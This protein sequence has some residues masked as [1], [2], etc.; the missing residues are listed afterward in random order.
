MSVLEPMQV[1]ESNSNP[2]N[3]VMVSNPPLQDEIEFHMDNDDHVDQDLPIA[4]RKG[5][6]ECTK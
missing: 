4:I 1:Q 5:T 6:R 2:S 3:E